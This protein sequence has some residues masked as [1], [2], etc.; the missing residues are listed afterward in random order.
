M[1]DSY[2]KASGLQH[3]KLLRPVCENSGMVDHAPSPGQTFC[4]TDPYV[5]SVCGS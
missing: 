2:Y 5:R 4:N 3:P 1:H